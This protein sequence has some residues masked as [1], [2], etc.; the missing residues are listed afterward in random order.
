[1]S[2]SEAKPSKAASRRRLAN[3]ILGFRA[4]TPSVELLIGVPEEAANAFGGDRLI[5]LVQR[6][7]L[8]G[9]VVLPDRGRASRIDD[10]QSPSSVVL[11][12]IDQDINGDPFPSE[13]P[14]QRGGDDLKFVV[15]S[16]P[17]KR[18]TTAVHIIWRSAHWT[19][20]DNRRRW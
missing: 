20:P 10:L 9:K 15:H 5:D 4:R 3:G 11:A 2:Q 12:P 14:A 19:S 7:L 6:I 8:G 16:A 17:P 18:V 13:F 1:M